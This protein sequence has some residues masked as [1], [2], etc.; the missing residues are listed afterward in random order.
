MIRRKTPLRRSMKPIRRSRIT[1]SRKTT[2]R[3]REESVVVKAVRPVVAER[4]GYCRLTWMDDV[5]RGQVAAIFG[6]CAGRSEWA[7][8]LKRWQT[9]GMAPSDRHDRTT[10]IMLCHFH[11]QDDRAGFDRH[12]FEIEPLTDRGA[13][14]PL[15]FRKN[16]RIWQEPA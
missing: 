13:D 14:G 9:R 5:T 10:S 7:H 8:L 3:R 16:K 15:R 12:A 4:D 6:P 11:H 1:P 2:Q